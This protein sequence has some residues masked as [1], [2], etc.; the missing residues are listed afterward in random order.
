MA[1]AIAACCFIP[2]GATLSR[3]FILRRISD[4]RQLEQRLPLALVAEIATLSRKSTR[5]NR[6]PHCTATLFEE[7]VNSL[8]TR[9]MFASP[10]R[11]RVKVLAITSAIKGEGKTSLAA[12]LAASVARANGRTLLIDGDM[13]SP[14]IHRIF[15]VKKSPG[16]AEILSGEATIDEAVVRDNQTN[17]DFLPAGQLSRPPDE[18]LGTGTFSQLLQ[19]FSSNYEFIVIDTPPV[20]SASETLV[21]AC[22]ADATILCAMRGRS[23]ELQSRL[24]FERLANA[25]APPIGAVLNGVPARRYQYTYGD[26]KYAV[27]KK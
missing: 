16:L 12:Q 2:L 4:P 26:Y 27:A 6:G 21:L 17:L 15:E 25:G 24:A 9:L 5:K 11:Q 14:D 3:E 8:R 18:L 10:N 23:R 19:Q 22:C 13:R 20:L 1:L 7:S